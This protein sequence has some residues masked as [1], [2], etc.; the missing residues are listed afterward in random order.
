MLVTDD[1][2]RDQATD[3]GLA[4]PLPDVGVRNRGDSN[5]RLRKAAIDGS[6]K[7][8]YTPT[9]F[10]LVSAQVPV[11]NRAPDERRRV[12]VAVINYDNVATAAY[13]QAQFEHA[14][15]HWNRVGIQI[16][17]QA[18]VNRPSP[19]GVLDGTGQ[20]PGSK[21]NAAEQAA[22]AD[23]IPLA[24]DGTLT[25]VFVPLSGA[26]AYATVGQRLQSAL[27]DRFF[28][29]VNDTLALTDETLAHELHHVLFNRFDTAVAQ[30]FYTFNTTAPSGFGIALPDVRVYGRIQNLNAPDPDND[31]NNDNILNWPKRARTARFPIAAGTSAATATTGNNFAQNF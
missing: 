7:G 5:H 28:I 10:P 4:A 23:L 18:T 16:D 24:A 15:T 29:F 27:V 21:D 6:V 19:A 31:A 13:I 8:E 25:V 20:Y 12:S 11:F 26:N 22:L 1:T 2:D 14:N 3:S 17:A 30:Q 9:G